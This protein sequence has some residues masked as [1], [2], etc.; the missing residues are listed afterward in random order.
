MKVIVSDKLASEGIKV[1]KAAGFEVLEA[2]EEPKEKLPELIKDCDAIVVRSA[3]KVRKDLI[4]AGKKL[5]VI[6]RAG[7][8][9]DNVDAD[10][11]KSKGIKVVNTP[12]ATTVTVAELTFTLML[13]SVRDV[14]TGTVTTREGKWEKK[15]L[16][17]TELYGKT[18]GIIGFGRIGGA[19]ADRAHAFGMNVL[20]YRRHPQPHP[21]VKFVD[22]DTL[23][24]ESDVI[25]I[26][27]PLTPETKHLL[28]ATSFEKMKKG[29]III[30]PG[31]G[32]T[33]DEEALYNAMVS[34]KV[35]FAALDTFEKEPPVDSKLLKLPNF[36]CTPHIGAQTT[37]G[38]LRAGIQIAEKVV[39]ELKALK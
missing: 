20:A 38:Q 15:T 18:L 33:I 11:A 36:I 22:L 16:K 29:V 10:Y 23:L 9:L 2:W 4:D 6:G 14:V 26:H 30:N 21:N 5:K 25:S 1:L 13:A 39:E 37:E 3:T 35:K 19:V 31:R 17:G 32:G 34:G 27:A 28:N 7:I 8:G 12:A 24:K